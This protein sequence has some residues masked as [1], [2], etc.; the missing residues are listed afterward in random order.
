MS[1]LL[2][3]SEL[4]NPWI[5]ENIPADEHDIKTLE[6]LFSEGN[7][8]INDAELL[9][10][11]LDHMRIEDDSFLNEI[12]NT[13]FYRKKAI[14]FIFTQIPDLKKLESFQHDN[15][16]FLF[17]PCYPQIIRF[18]INALLHRGQV[19]KNLKHS[20]KQ[21]QKFVGIVSHDLRSPITNIK[22]I[23]ELFDE[24][25][26]NLPI[27]LKSLSK[28]A[29]WAFQLINDL[30]DLTAM[31]TGRIKLE[32][33]YCDFR[34]IAHEAISETMLQAERKR[35]NIV[36]DTSEEQK[37]YID[38]KRVLQ[39]LINL[40]WNAIKFTPRNG[41]IF[42]KNSVK[43][44]RLQVEICDNGVGI[45]DEVLPKLFN[46]H[47]KVFTIGTEGEAGTGY[48]LPLSQELIMAHGSSIRYKKNEPKG[49]CFFF[50]LPLHA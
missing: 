24:T 33:D 36:Y 26:D 7:G 47:E 4:D 5:Q 15:S 29:E 9:I 46:K 2:F 13:D 8:D 27:F 40:L 49:S 3:Y 11:A 22:L 45:S 48:G 21:M 30:L 6:K 35:I 16:D 28:S 43:L 20:H 50:D 1:F 17:L 14:L 39:V 37:V 31:E 12:Q 32:P 41:T 42:I 23:S 18:K 10:L 19:M 34:S 25:P 44:D 38:K